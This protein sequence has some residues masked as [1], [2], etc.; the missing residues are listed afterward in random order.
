MIEEVKDFFGDVKDNV[1]DKGFLVL[2]LGAVAFG[3]YNLLKNDSVGEVVYT[4]YD[5][6][7]VDSIAENSDV[8]MDSVNQTIESSFSEILNVVQENEATNA[9][10]FDA[11][12]NYINESMGAVKD[13]SDK[14][15]SIETEPRVEYVTQYVPQY[16]TE[17]VKEYVYVPSTVNDIEE[18]ETVS[19]VVNVIPKTKASEVVADSKEYY[20]YQNKTGLNT[21]TS[22]VDALKA[23]G[24]N[25][26]MTNRQK[27]AEANGIS[28][29][30]G[31]YS[32]N[33][34]LLNKLKE[35]T[36][37]KPTSAVAKSAVL[38]TGT[39][40]SITSKV[41]S[42]KAQSTTAPKTSTKAQNAVSQLGL[43]DKVKNAIASYKAKNASGTG[44][45]TTTENTSAIVAN[46]MK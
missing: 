12:N 23:T 24:E 42:T 33:V 38:A 19:S 1:G 30:T 32:Q 17:Y 45:T 41:T 20:Q 37:M 27:I 13:L 26:S 44:N 18:E 6:A 28:N 29:Y 46:N 40:E 7:N 3:L 34:T 31:T 5:D 10:K 36:L 21:S 35:G 2:I 14:V 8:I 4:S 25:S 11:L 39:T 43:S 22:I 15:D 16:N 9:E